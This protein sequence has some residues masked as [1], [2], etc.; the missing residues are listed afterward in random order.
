M[1]T[2]VARLHH[3]DLLYDTSLCV[4]Q[5]VS[6]DDQSAQTVA[7]TRRYQRFSTASSD[8][9]YETAVHHSATKSMF[10]FVYSRESLDTFH[11]SGVV[12]HSRQEIHV[13]VAPDLH[14][15]R[16]H[17][18]YCCRL[19]CSQCPNPP[20]RLRLQASLHH[21]P[22]KIAGV[23]FVDLVCVVD[24][25]MDQLSES[26]KLL[27]EDICSLRD[28]FCRPSLVDLGV[29]LLLSSG[30][31]VSTTEIVYKFGVWQTSGRWSTLGE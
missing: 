4:N 16:H 14:F 11:H 12:R 22:F 5:R 7:S 3:V 17:L 9:M 18:C 6:K 27:G 23:S 10:G 19:A 2:S 24:R 30:L 29:S 25:A 13:P 20:A 31:Q 8:K 1:N 28:R 26:V 15:H 21:Q